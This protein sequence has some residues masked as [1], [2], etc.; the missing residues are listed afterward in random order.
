VQRELIGHGAFKTVYKAY[1][2]EEGI[3][4]AWN[5]VRLTGVQPQQRAKIL[6]EITILEQL[7]HQNIMDIY[8]SWETPSGD[9]LI[10]ITEIMSSGTLKTYVY[11]FNHAI[12]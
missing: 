1:D 3:E 12:T 8:D 11:L 9:Y 6:G 5:Q 7:K 2:T 10:F 4:V